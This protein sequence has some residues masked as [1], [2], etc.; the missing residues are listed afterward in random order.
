MVGCE[1]GM[2]KLA[3]FDVAQEAG[4]KSGTYTTPKLPVS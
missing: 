3:E 4:L 2:A 1:C